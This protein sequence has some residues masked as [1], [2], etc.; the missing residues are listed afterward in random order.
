M[1]VKIVKGPVLT[2]IVKTKV[3]HIFVVRNFNILFIYF[4]KLYF[5]GN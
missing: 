2:C 1:N 4:H 5:T 3:K